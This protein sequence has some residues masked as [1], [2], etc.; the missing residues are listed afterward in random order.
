MIIRLQSSISRTFQFLWSKPQTCQY[1]WISRSSRCEYFVSYFIHGKQYICSVQRLFIYIRSRGQS[2]CQWMNSMEI[3]VES[4]AGVGGAAGER[5]YAETDIRSMCALPQPWHIPQPAMIPEN[6]NGF[7]VRRAPGGCHCHPSD[8]TA[9]GE[10]REESS[11]WSQSGRLA[12]LQHRQSVIKQQPVN[13][14]ATICQ[15]SDYFERISGILDKK[16]YDM[17]DRVLAKYFWKSPRETQTADCRLQTVVSCWVAVISLCRLAS[18]HYRDVTG[19][20]HCQLQ[21]YYILSYST[22]RK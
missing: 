6:S 14:T 11:H 1:I 7:Q 17:A 21:H 18:S 2:A 20:S 19:T 5:S 4:R 8:E 9:R 15:F 12:Q 10:R 13:V 3:S 16:F 22:L